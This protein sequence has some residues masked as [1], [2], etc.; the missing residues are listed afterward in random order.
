MLLSANDVTTSK[1]PTGNFVINPI[2]CS[3]VVYPDLIMHHNDDHVIGPFAN[4]FLTIE[5]LNRCDLPSKCR[6]HNTNRQMPFVVS[7]CLS[8]RLTGHGI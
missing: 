4:N 5:V 1:V 7:V 2:E 8:L 6:N 3:V